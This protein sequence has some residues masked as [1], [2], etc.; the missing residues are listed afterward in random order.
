MCSP[1]FYKEWTGPHRGQC[2]PCS[3]NRLS[4]LCDAQTGNC[5]VSV[6]QICTHHHPMTHNDTCL[7]A[8]SQQTHMVWHLPGQMQ[9]VSLML[10]VN[11]TD[12]QNCQFNSTGDR[13]ERCKE[14]YYGNA[15]NRT[16]HACPCPLTQNKS[17]SVGYLQSFKSLCLALSI[18]IFCSILVLRWAVWMLAQGSLNVCANVVTVEHDVR[19]G[20]QELTH[21]LCTLQ[22]NVL[23]LVHT[24][25]ALCVFPFF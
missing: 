3:C 1:G 5:V 23:I 24:G 11:L 10:C 16:C 6:S 4:N 18:N 15:A 2:V 8:N 9:I 12:L 17:V 22:S 21:A 20:T 14:G 13:C 19:G 7:V 25:H